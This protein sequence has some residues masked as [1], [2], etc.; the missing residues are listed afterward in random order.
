MIKPN[1][2]FKKKRYIKKGVTEKKNNQERELKKKNVQKH[3]RI[4]RKKEI[5]K[6]TN[7]HAKTNKYEKMPN[8]KGNRQTS[9]F[10]ICN[11]SINL[12]SERLWTEDKRKRETHV[13]ETIRNEEKKETTDEQMYQQKD[14]KRERMRVKKKLKSFFLYKREIVV[15]KNRVQE[16]GDQ[17]NKRSNKKEMKKEVNAKR[18]EQ[19]QEVMK[20]GRTK[21]L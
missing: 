5:S 17:E 10:K 7:K 19:K 6:K 2:V 12:S 20:I 14:I 4:K 16:E 21:N 1:R 9:V 3:M 18:D 15:Q 11:S 13:W 8:K